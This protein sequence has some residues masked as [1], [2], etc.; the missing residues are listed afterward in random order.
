[1]TDR[2]D[3][4]REYPGTP[5]MGVGALIVAENEILLVRRGKEPSKGEWSIPGGLVRVGETLRDAVI[6]EAREETGFRVEPL[7][8]VE[9]LERIFPDNQGRIRY[10]YVLADYLCRVIGG[11]LNAGSDASEAIWVNHEQLDSFPLAP[12]TLRV[13]RKALDLR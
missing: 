1:M 13:I 11:E 4:R 9:L 8:L 3:I 10:H 6:R 12:V 7:T 2:S 5:L